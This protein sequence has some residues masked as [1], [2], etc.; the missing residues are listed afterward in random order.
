MQFS[1]LWCHRT[2]PL[3]SAVPVLS[4]YQWDSQKH[5]ILK[6][7]LYTWPYV[8]LYSQL[9]GC[10]YMRSALPGLPDALPWSLGCWCESSL[11]C[12]D[13]L[14]W[15]C[16]WT[17]FETARADHCGCGKMSYTQKHTTLQHAWITHLYKKQCNV[18]QLSLDCLLLAVPLTHQWAVSQTS[19]S[20]QFPGSHFG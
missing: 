16:C 12:G 4:S 1:R 20:L 14:R 15:A 2:F 18:M 17:A 7:N 13:P 10:V 19:A 8:N 9:H 11:V 6:T 5:E 3:S